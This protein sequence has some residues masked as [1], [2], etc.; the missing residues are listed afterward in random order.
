[1]LPRCICGTYLPKHISIN[2][3]TNTLRHYSLN[4]VINSKNYSCA[5]SLAKFSHG[6]CP[7]HFFCYYNKQTK[8]RQHNE[9][10]LATNVARKSMPRPLTTTKTITCAC[11]H[12]TYSNHIIELTQ[13]HC[14]C[15]NKKKKRIF[16]ERKKNAK[17]QAK[18]SHVSQVHVLSLHKKKPHLRV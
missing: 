8:H 7:K 10:F 2:Y 11:T 18:T 9:T 4:I 16:N 5:F 3:I 14:F 17:F 12:N 6:R 15:Y 13:E 1:M